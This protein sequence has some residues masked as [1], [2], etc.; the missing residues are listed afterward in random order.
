MLSP[1]HSLLAHVRPTTGNQGLSTI[2]QVQEPT[3]RTR[4]YQ[5]PREGWPM[6]PDR[7]LRD[8]ISPGLARPG[9]VRVKVAPPT[10]MKALDIT[11]RAH[12]PIRDA[13]VRTSQQHHVQQ[14]VLLPPHNHLQ[15]LCPR[16]CHTRTMPKWDDGGL[17]SPRRRE[18]GLSVRLLVKEAW[19]K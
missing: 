17:P 11:E 18:H 12:G 19:G 9:G 15:R 2:E 10:K 7:I 4:T 13:I 16:P 6:L 1:P 8:Q 5:M 3:S 14:M